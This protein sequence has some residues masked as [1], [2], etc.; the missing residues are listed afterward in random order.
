MLC[1]LLQALKYYL[2]R[3]AGLKYFQKNITTLKIGISEINYVKNITLM[4]SGF[5]QLYELRI[6]LIV[7]LLESL[8]IIL[9]NLCCFFNSVQQVCAES[10]SGTYEIYM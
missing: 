9:S 4:A 7:L 6:N 8:S 2:F 5:Y 10:L 3:N 1:I